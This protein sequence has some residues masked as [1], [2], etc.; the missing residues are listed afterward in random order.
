VTK[1]VLVPQIIRQAA[2]AGQPA[3]EDSADGGE[4]RWRFVEGDEI[5]PGRTAIRLLGGGHRYEAYLGWDDRLHSLV[6]VKVV[7]P[8]LVDDAHTL[9][10]LESE[11]RMLER[12]SHPVI[13]RSFGAQLGGPR[14]HMVLEH[15]EGPRLSTLVRKYG[16]LPAEQLVPLALQVSAAIHYL[17]GEGVVHLD[18]KPSNI[19]MGSPPR[20]VDLSVARTLE[21]CSEL[22][23]GVGTDGYMSPE[24]CEPGHRGAVRPAADVWGLGATLFHAGTG[25]RPFRKGDPKAGVAEE[26][27]PQLVEPPRPADGLPPAIADPIMACL[28]YDPSDRPSPADVAARLEPVLAGLPK[29]RISRLR[30]RLGR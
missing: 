9:E 28:A 2:P 16:P 12:L 15:L 8:G 13:V 7:R 18:V 11:V 14:P 21:G 5:T 25:Q 6:V 1:P 27:W 19:I 17:A 3:R 24:Q 26:R 10:G 23:S 4:T 30:P 29:P 20:L 22:R